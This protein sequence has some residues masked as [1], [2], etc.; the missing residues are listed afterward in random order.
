MAKLSVN[1]DHIATLRQARGTGYP[2]PVWGA[3]IVELAGAN[4]LTMHLRQDERHITERDL[5]LIREVITI[6]LTLEMAAT[7]SM[8]EKALT[9]RPECV[10]LVPER[11]G[12][13]TTEGGFDVRG[14]ATNLKGCIERLRAEGIVVCLFINPDEDS[15]KLSADLGADYVEL[16]TDDYATAKSYIEEVEELRRLEKIA[17]LGQKKGLGVNA[18]HGLNY[19]NVANVADVEAIEELSIGHSII[20]RAIFVGLEKAI[21]EMLTLVR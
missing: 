12:E 2:E 7:E 3:S 11:E 1:I 9:Y 14:E 21:K 4:G 17:V 19:N 16:N 6:P 13:R 8:V 10:T 5:R 20:S 18:G 15:V